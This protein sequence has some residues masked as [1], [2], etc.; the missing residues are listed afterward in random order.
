MI[1][2]V[3][4]FTGTQLGMSVA[5]KETIISLLEKYPV[6]E[7]HH[8]DCIGADADMHTIAVCLNI[9]VVIHPPEKPDKRAFCIAA[10]ERIPL[11]YLER[12]EHI[13]RESISMLAAPSGPEVLR[14]GTWSTIRRAIKKNKPV[15]I[16]WPDGSVERR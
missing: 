13:I 4:G 11:P 16:V 15:T 8:G 2:M 10:T 6:D 1:R 5:Q 9:P 3:L 12:N 7:I 14:S